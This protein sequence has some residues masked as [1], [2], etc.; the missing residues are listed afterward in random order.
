MFHYTG[1][2]FGSITDHCSTNVVSSQFQTQTAVPDWCLDYEYRVGNSWCKYKLY[3]S[4]FKALNPT[5]VDYAKTI[6]QI[7]SP[8]RVGLNPVINS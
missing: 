2:R 3:S 1:N 5:K 6:L 7:N 4:I 8:Q